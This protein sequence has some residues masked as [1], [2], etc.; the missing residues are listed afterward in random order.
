MLVVVDATSTNAF[1]DILIDLYLCIRFR[2]Y[3]YSLRALSIQSRQIRG[4]LLRI[5]G[6]VRLADLRLLCLGIGAQGS[7]TKWFRTKLIQVHLR[8]LQ[9]DYSTTIFTR[10]IIFN[11]Y[12]S[13]PTWHFGL[14]SFI[15][16]LLL[17]DLVKIFL[18]QFFMVSLLTHEII[19]LFDI[20]FGHR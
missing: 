7:Q 19:I 3:D 1:N 10:F 20:S 2:A 18:I 5:G 4:K 14:L 9:V 11:A 15:K 16:L 13:D 17:G 6:R 8:D 12:Y